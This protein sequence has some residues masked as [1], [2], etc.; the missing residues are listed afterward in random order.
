ME[1]EMR[2]IRYV[3]IFSALLGLAG[4]GYAI[5]MMFFSPDRIEFAGKSLS[6]LVQ[7]GEILAAIAIPVALIISGILM[8][9][10]VRILF[11]SEIKNGVTTTA[12]VLKVWDTGV[13]IND[14]P[15]VGMLLEIT[16]PEGNS[17]K[18]EAKTLV[19]RLIT[20]LVQP[21][22]KAEVKYDP[23][24]LKRIHVENILLPEPASVGATARL[25]EL[26]AMRE[27]DLISRE[28]YEQK[29]SEILKSL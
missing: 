21:G 20:A 24:N 26:E 9:N 22:I 29:R 16:S 1:G 17:I 28:E 10:F 27:K 4:F 15:Q 23:K 14:N 6:E 12:T 8:M 11:P 2:S 18:A 3:L 7:S 5:Y 25:E 13:S 19:S